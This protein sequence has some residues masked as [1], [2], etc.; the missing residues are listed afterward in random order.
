MAYLIYLN[1]HN[2][3]FATYTYTHVHGV[4]RGMVLVDSMSKK[5]LEDKNGVIG[6]G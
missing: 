5:S 6:T 1:L 2:K 3:V 4:Q